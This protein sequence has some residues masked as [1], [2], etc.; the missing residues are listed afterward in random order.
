MAP[1]EPV[2]CP[3]TVPKSVSERDTEGDDRSNQVWGEGHRTQEGETRYGAGVSNLSL[4]VVM[5]A[6][7]SAAGSTPTT[8]FAS[9]WK[10]LDR[11]ISSNSAGLPVNQQNLSPL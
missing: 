3:S 10:H 1:S 2:Q 8:P 11:C 5:F 7:A 6:A 9:I 4:L